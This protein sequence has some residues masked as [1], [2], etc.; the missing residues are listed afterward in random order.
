M[1]GV[2]I[3]LHVEAFLQVQ[4][5]FA[6]PREFLPE[7]GVGFFCSPL[8]LMRLGI[9]YAIRQPPSSFKSSISGLQRFSSSKHTKC[10]Q[11]C[12]VAPSLGLVLR[13]GAGEGNGG[14]G[15]PGTPSPPT[16]HSAPSATKIPPF[17]PPL[18]PPPPPLS[19]NQGPAD[20]TRLLNG[21]FQNPSFAFQ[22]P[23]CCA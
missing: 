11:G 10:R 20:T 1:Y 14:N 3:N 16:K 4:W 18:E 7:Q 17:A 21:A 5:L 2:H 19:R 15:I 13:W 8:L 12:L 6:Y 9:V 22:I 23:G